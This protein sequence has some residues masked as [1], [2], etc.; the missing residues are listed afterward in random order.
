MMK[1]WQQWLSQRSPRE[2]TGIQWAA[3]L[4][5]VWLVWTW[6]VAPAWQV[7]SSSPALRER[8]AQQRSEMQGLQQQALMLQNAPRVSTEQAAQVLQQLTQAAGPGLTFKRQGPQ[9]QVGFKG[10]SPN[11]LADL[12]R[13]SSSQA[14]A[15][16]QSAQLQQKDK[17]WEGQLVFGLPTQP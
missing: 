6:A 13:Q 3:G 7:L 11:A 17:A 12:L 15:R 14:Q 1:A 10:L 16:V 2:Q 9:V 4:A 8:F 5:L